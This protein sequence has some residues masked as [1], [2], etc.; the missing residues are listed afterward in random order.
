MR[1]V[2]FT[3]FNQVLKLNNRIFRKKVKEIVRDYGIEIIVCGP[4]HYLHGFPPFNMSIP[5]VFD[6]VD[7]LY[8]FNN[9]YVENTKILREYY[10]NASK[11]L[12]VS[13]TLLDSIIPKYKEKGE[14]LPNGVDL[15]FFR[16]YKNFS[17]KKRNN[18]KIVSLIGINLSHSLF[19]LDIFPEIK[20]EVENVKFL[21]VG[22]GPKYPLIENYIKT[23]KEASDYILTGFVSYEK[24]REYFYMTDVGLNPTLQN[25]YFDCQCPLK[26]MEYSAVN[27]PVVSTDLDELRRLKFPNVFL[28]KPNKED[29]IKKIIK[30]LNYS[31]PFP[32]LENFDWKNISKKLD[33]ILSNI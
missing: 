4:N 31:G 7:Y 13:K 14:Y 18:N 15:E 1:H 19:Y 6:Y 22:S 9:P 26:I 16:N 3:R 8:E 11:I 10:K 20:R 23:N 32:N 21:L 28:S 5:F 27:K 29:Y 33:T 2:Y 12:C 30:A 17:K 24:V 25:R